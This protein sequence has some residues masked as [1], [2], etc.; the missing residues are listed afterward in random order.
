MNSPARGRECARIAH[1]SALRRSLE[2]A[3]SRWG[4]FRSSLPLGGYDAELEILERYERAA[5]GSVGNYTVQDEMI[6]DR[7]LRRGR[8]ATRRR[9]PVMMRVD[10][11]DA[12]SR[13]PHD[14]AS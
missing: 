7:L 10:Y 12:P 1:S 4:H 2:S 6:N 8:S 9:A 3:T 5:R 13:E 11:G 14:Y